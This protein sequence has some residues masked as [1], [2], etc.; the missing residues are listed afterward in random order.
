MKSESQSREDDQSS[1]DRPPSHIMGERKTGRTFVVL[2]SLLTGL[3][4]TVDLVTPLGVAAGVP[5]VVVVLLTPWLGE[6]RYTWDAAIGVTLLTV[7]GFLLAPP[8]GVLWMVIVNRGLA[9]FAIWVTAILILK[10]AEEDLLHS[11]ELQGGIVDTAYDVIITIDQ[12]GV[13]QSFNPAGEEAFG[14]VGSEVIGKNVKVLMPE[15]YKSRHDADMKTYLETGEAKVIGRLSEL[16]ARHKNGTTFPIELAISEV[17]LGNRRLFTGIIRDITERKS[18]EEALRFQAA[19][20][21]RLA[22]GVSLLRVSDLTIVYVNP[23]LERIFGYDPGELIGK[24]VAVL[25]ARGETSPEETVSRIVRSLSE[26]GSW[27]G[28]VHN[29]KKD[30]TKFWTRANVSRLDHQEFGEVWLSVQVDITEQKKTQEALRSSQERL[31]LAGSTHGLWDWNIEA[32]EVFISTRFK[33]L[34]GFQDDE[35]DEVRNL[36]ASHVHPDDYDHAR[37]A[38]TDHLEKRIPYDVEYR[39]RAKSGEYLWLAIRG[40]A[41]WDESGKPVRMAGTVTEI[42]DRKHAEEELKRHDETLAVLLREVNHC[43][44]NNLATIISL[45]HKE[46]DRS[47]HGR[48]GRLRPRAA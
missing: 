36:L 21:E 24:N 33:Q 19:L 4:F 14:Y 48:T 1:G 46:G 30:G 13:I 16:E 9:I 32:D 42:N 20:V 39:L 41:V 37:K 6:K 31:A 29:V 7:L 45:I 22:E 27:S 11:A 8:G 35:I 26:T 23:T 44:T 18:S 40:Q 12:D 43:V 15:L 2:A 25:N 17:R 38:T 10:R 34:L 47:S 5:Y 28:E 3:I